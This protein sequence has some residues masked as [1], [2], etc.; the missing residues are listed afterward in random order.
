MEAVTQ[1]T[2]SR[3]GTADDTDRFYQHVD[4]FLVVSLIRSPF[5]KFL[6]R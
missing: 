4:D 1:Q 2:L 5:S 3:Q 6:Q